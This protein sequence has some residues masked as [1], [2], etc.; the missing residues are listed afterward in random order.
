MSYHIYQVL[1][2]YGHHQ[3]LPMGAFEDLQEAQAFKDELES[4]ASN[5]NDIFYGDDFFIRPILVK[6]KGDL[7]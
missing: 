3:D 2:V 4:K 1:A 6:E 7:V 5:E